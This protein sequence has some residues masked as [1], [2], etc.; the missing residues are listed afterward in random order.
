LAARVTLPQY[1]NVI[2]LIGSNIDPI[3]NIKQAIAEVSAIFQINKKSSLWETRPIGTDGNNFFNL[4]LCISTSLDFDQ[5]KFE[6]LRNIEIRLGRIRIS[7]KYAPRTIDIDIILD[8]NMIVDNNI[9][10]YAYIAVPVAEIF[11]ELIQPE[12]NQPLKVVAAM[13]IKNSWI[14]KHPAKKLQ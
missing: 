7:D 9:W 6:I 1:R 10:R 11:P 2:L 14:K 8:G 12:T 5:L 4:A 13:L 3:S